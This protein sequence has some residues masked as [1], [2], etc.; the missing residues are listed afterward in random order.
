M[1]KISVQVSLFTCRHCGQGYNNRI[2]HVCRVPFNQLAQRR[3]RSGSKPV[4]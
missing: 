1:P 3:V 4:K 2:S